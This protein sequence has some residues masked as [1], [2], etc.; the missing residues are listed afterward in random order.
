MSV[1]NVH[2]NYS[3]VEGQVLEVTHRPGSFLRANLSDASAHNESNTLVIQG[4]ARIIMKQIAG[5]VARRIVC[6]TRKGDLLRSG[7][8]IGLIQ[9]GSRVDL[10]LPSSVKVKVKEGD[11]VKGGLS[12]LGVLKES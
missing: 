4:K 6:Y 8:K 11:K 12:I 5:L 7:Q 9:F 2:I 1:L 3:P 10:Y